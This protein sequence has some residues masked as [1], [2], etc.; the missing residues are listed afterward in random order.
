MWARL[1]RGLYI[2]IWTLQSFQ[3]DSINFFFVLGYPAE[4]RFV[5]LMFCIIRSISEG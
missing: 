5:I 3:E 2:F 1:L 4:F